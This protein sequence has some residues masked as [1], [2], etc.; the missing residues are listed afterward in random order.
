MPG[1]SEN[2][3]ILR[4]SLEKFEECHVVLVLSAAVNWKNNHRLYNSFQGLGIDSIALT[5]FDL[6]ATRGT[7]LNLALGDYPPIYSITDS[8][9]PTGRV[10]AFDSAGYLKTL[11]GGLDA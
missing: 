10:S 3:Q 1:D 11:L 9:L 8:R 5:Q 4:N 2:A 7:I 6:T